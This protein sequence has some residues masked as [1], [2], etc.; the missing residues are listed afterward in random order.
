LPQRWREIQPPAGAV[1]VTY[2]H[3]GMRSWHAALYLESVGLAPVLSLAG[4]VDA[5]SREV[6]PSLPRY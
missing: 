5:W 1:L 2:C 6:D 3:H 4:G